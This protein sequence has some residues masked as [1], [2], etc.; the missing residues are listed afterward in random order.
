MQ[1]RDG[2]SCVGD[3]YPATVSRKQAVLCAH[4][5][6]ALGQYEL[7]PT[8]HYLETSKPQYRNMTWNTD[9]RTNRTR[10]AWL[11][12]AKLSHQ[13]WE[14][15]S[16]SSRTRGQVVFSSVEQQ[17]GLDRTCGTHSTAS[18]KERVR[19]TLNLTEDAG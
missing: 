18:G 1:L 16:F 15:S 12:M 4:A 14:K 5:R 11:P 2:W 19:L 10:C 8:T 13:L 17:R 9:N 3:N 6:Q 7:L